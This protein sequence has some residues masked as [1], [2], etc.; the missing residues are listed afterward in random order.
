MGTA[1]PLRKCGTRHWQP[2]GLL[3]FG[4][5]DWRPATAPSAPKMLSCITHP[6]QFWPASEA[7]WASSA[8]MAT[9]HLVPAKLRDLYHVRE[10]RNAAG[11]LTTACP[12]EWKDI[13]EVLES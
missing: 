10:W 1:C 13:C 6:A 8:P 2:F 11:I 5:A 3:A 12:N 9:E 4:S 7:F